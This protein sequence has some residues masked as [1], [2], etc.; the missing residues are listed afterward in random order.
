MTST[1]QEK[2]WILAEA[3]AAKKRASELDIEVVRLTEKT[4][5]QDEEI[6][7]Q[8]AAIEKQGM[9]MKRVLDAFAQL[10]SNG[11]IPSFPLNASQSSTPT[12][13]LASPTSNDETNA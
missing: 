5:K 4:K 3:E 8:H 10:A 1:T 2:C 6:Q 11:L 7:A 13:D 12:N 9:E